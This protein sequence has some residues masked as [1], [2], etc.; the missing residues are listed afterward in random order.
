MSQN[1]MKR[2]NKDSIKLY[3]VYWRIY[4]DS[5]TAEEIL[6]SSDLPAPL[7]LGNLPDHQV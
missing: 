4:D 2:L 1:E 3:L 5:K 7:S 6:R